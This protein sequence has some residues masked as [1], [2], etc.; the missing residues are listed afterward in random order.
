MSE[1]NADPELDADLAAEQAA[2]LRDERDRASRLKQR[3]DEI[4]RTICRLLW[5]AACFPAGLAIYLL[6]DSFLEQQVA[7]SLPI[8]TLQGM[9]AAG[10]SRGGVV[11]QT[12]S[13]Y[14]PLKKPIAAAQGV[15]LTVAVRRNG[16]RYVCSPGRAT[17]VATVRRSLE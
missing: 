16:S 13:G 12:E 10:G 7:S 9:S 3:L 1:T 5:V 4:H 6:R 14:Y 11:L 8:G 17:C 2:I 15:A